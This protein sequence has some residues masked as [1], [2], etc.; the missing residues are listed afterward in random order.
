MIKLYIYIY[1]YIYMEGRFY[2]LFLPPFPYLYIPCIYIHSPLD[3]FKTSLLA[4]LKLG[5][6]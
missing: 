3:Y 4:L 6:R 2:A 5:L 1:I